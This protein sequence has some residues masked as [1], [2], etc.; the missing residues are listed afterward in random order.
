MHP[1][2]FLSKILFLLGCS[3][4]ISQN[5][6]DIHN[7][8]WRFALLI[9]IP[10]VSAKYLRILAATPRGFLASPGQKNY[11]SAAYALSTSSAHFHRYPG[12]PGHGRL[13][14]WHT[15]MSP[16][17]IGYFENDFSRPNWDQFHTVCFSYGSRQQFI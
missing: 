7:M 15:G 9:M 13:F 10:L 4:I 12:T 16:G 11:L 8:N 5:H 2:L 6:W 3:M 1:V 14:A 17:L